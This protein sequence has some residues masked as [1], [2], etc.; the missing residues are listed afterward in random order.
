MAAVAEVAAFL[1]RRLTD[2]GVRVDQARI[3]SAA[4]LHDVDKLVWPKG[5][6]PGRHGE[7]GARWLAERGYPELELPVSGHP[8]SLLSDDGRYAGWR[9]R[10]DRETRVV[11]YADKRAG[12]RLVP[13]AGRFR[14]WRAKHPDYAPE[15]ERA[16]GRALALERAICDECG[17]APD[18][19][20]RLRWV[21]QAL[22]TVDRA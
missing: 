17:L 15:L 5:Q 9:R 20:R 12:Q 6:R 18:E 2:R 19:V 11:A 7:A 22:R 21:R 1:A 10:A 8:V 3:E 14:A 16:W 13:M 4:L